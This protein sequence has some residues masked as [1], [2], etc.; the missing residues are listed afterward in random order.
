MVD[1]ILGG[2]SVLQPPNG[3][4]VFLQVFLS[5]SFPKK[6]RAAWAISWGSVLLLS[7]HPL[8]LGGFQR[9]NTE[10]H[11]GIEPPKKETREACFVYHHIYKK[12]K[13]FVFWLLKLLLHK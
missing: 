11:L 5:V 12:N 1:M 4:L 6:S 2:C 9:G 10:I 13:V 8:F 7:W 3:W